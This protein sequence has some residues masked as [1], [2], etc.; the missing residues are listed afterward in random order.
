LPSE[1]EC[2]HSLKRKTALFGLVDAFPG[3][4][5]PLI[6]WAAASCRLNIEAVILYA[7]LFLW[8]F[9]YFMAI[10]WMYREEYD[11]AGY[12]VL[13]KG[14][15]RAPFM[16]LETLSPLLALVSISFMQPPTRHAP[17]F[18]CSAVLL[19]GAFLC[20]GLDFVLQRSRGSARRLLAASIAYLPSLFIFRAMLY[21]T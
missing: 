7:M 2:R 1:Q 6:G 4:T 3:A 10:A 13:P 15:M 12:V 9:P 21:T 8:Q 16:I 18:Y 17:I 20:F 11:R 5:P 14:D 19:S